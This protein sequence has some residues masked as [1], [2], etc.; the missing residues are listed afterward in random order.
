MIDSQASETEGVETDS[1]LSAFGQA[2]DGGFT[3]LHS[4]GSPG[5]RTPADVSRGKK[6]VKPPKA[7]PS[8]LVVADSAAKSLEMEQAGLTAQ[9]LCSGLGR[10]ALN[11]R[12]RHQWLP[13]IRI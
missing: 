3:K 12:H 8:E 1:G 13:K 9:R 6:K 7:K 5:K 2:S 11:L 10:L 4:R